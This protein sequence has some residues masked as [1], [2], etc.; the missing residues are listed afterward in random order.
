MTLI[1][2][3]TYVKFKN[4]KMASTNRLINLN[5]HDNNKYTFTIEIK[6]NHFDNNLFDENLLIFNDE[7]NSRYILGVKIA[8]PR[9]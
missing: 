6:L 7:N 2:S 3:L 4:D 9:S 1:T 8:Q 5:K